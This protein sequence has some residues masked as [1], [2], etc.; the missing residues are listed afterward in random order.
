MRDQTE[1]AVQKMENER[2][3]RKLK[4]L[5]IYPEDERQIRLEKHCQ[6]KKLDNM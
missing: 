4:E 2:Q 5:D 3:I 1:S 6:G